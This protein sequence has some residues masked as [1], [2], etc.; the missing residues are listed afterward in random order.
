MGPANVAIAFSF[1]PVDWRGALHTSKSLYA[2]ALAFGICCTRL[3]R[4][5]VNF[6]ITNFFR[7]TNLIVSDFN[8]LSFCLFFSHMCMVMRG[9]QKIN[10][11]TVTSTMLGVFRDDPKTREEFLN[12]VNTK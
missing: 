12:L 5:L 3:L 6:C 4:F 7:K 1:H 11:K 9:V 8:F 2:I 10:S